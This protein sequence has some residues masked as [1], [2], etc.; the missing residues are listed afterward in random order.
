MTVLRRVACIALGA[1]LVGACKLPKK[2]DSPPADPPYVPKDPA[3]P[4]N[5]GP[6]PPSAAW[7]VASTTRSEL[8]RSQW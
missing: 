5:F 4:G 7:V 3:N 8:E 2:P 1:F 6:R